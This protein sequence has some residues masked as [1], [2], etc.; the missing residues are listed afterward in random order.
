MCQLHIKIRF[1]IRVAGRES[2]SRGGGVERREIER[3]RERDSRVYIHIDTCAVCDK[4]DCLS[5]SSIFGG[6]KKGTGRL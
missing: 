3:E 1:S 5:S 6:E 4:R 2:A